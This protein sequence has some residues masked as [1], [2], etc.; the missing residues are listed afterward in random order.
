MADTLKL[1]IE[2]DAAK[3]KIT[4]IDLNKELASI[5]RNGSASAGGMDQLT[6]SMLG[7]SSAARALGSALGG[8]SLIALAKQAIELSASF[9]AT[10]MGIRA[11][12]G[13]FKIADDLLRNLEDF[14]RTSPFNFTNLTDATK[15]LLAYGFTAESI[16]PMLKSVGAASSA[17]GLGNDGISRMTLSL[18]QMKAAGKATGEELREMAQAGVPVWEILSKGFEKTPGQMRKA[19]EAGIVP[20]D[21]AIRILLEGMDKRFGSAFAAA[22][23]STKTVMSNLVDD[24]QKMGREIGDIFAPGLKAWIEDIRPKISEF[25]NDVKAHSGDILAFAGSLGEIAKVIVAYEVI[26][27]IGKLTVAIQGLTAASA[28]NPFTIIAAG[29]AILTV[30]LY[31]QYRQL[32]DTAAKF[33]E[34]E[35]NTRILDNLKTGKSVEEMQ[36]LGFS[37]EQIK[38]ALQGANPL[39]EQFKM[40]PKVLAGVTLG[41][42]LAKPDSKKGEFTS[43]PDKAANSA[44]KTHEEI[45]RKINELQRE[46][47]TGVAKLIVEQQQELVR[48]KAKKATSEDIAKLNSAYAVAIK[49]Q[50][51]ELDKQLDKI[52]NT[53]LAKII[54]QSIEWTK[55][56]FVLAENLKKVSFETDKL[57][58]EAGI[59]INNQMALGEQAQKESKLS[60]LDREDARGGLTIA[61]QR[62]MNKER[63]AIE[64]EYQNMYSL[65]QQSSIEEKF[66]IARLETELNVQ[67]MNITDEAKAHQLKARLDILDRLKNTELGGVQINTEMAKNRAVENEANSSARLV[68]DYYR[69]T[70]SSLKDQAGR[71]LDALFTKSE[72]VWK[73]MA[74]SF[75]AAFLTAFK[76]IV[77]SQIAKTLMG[78]FTGQSVRFQPNTIGNGS[79]SGVSRTLQ[80]LGATGASIMLPDGVGWGMGFSPLGAGATP[81]VGYGTDGSEQPRGAAKLPGIGIFGR[82][83]DTGESYRSMLTSLGGLGRGSGVGVS[84]INSVPLSEQAGLSSAR[85]VG[86][87]AG[88]AML[89]GGGMLAFDGLR[90]GGWLGAAETTGGGALI[91]AKFGGPVGAAIG[92]G[93]GFA[94]GMIRMAFKSATDKMRKRVKEMTGIDVKEKSVLQSMVEGAK[95]FGNFDL[96]INSKAG[97]ELIELYAQ[98]TNQKFKSKFY[99]QNLTMVQSGGSLYEMPAFYG[100]GQTLNPLT[101]LPGLGFSSSIDSLSLSGSSTGSTTVTLQID[102]A[103]TTKLM[104]GEAVNVIANNPRLIASSANAASRSS[105]GRQDQ[106]INLL[107]P[108]LARA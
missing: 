16:L 99:G 75:K 52:S 88:G 30:H 35:D 60:W 81:S 21:D 53:R 19:V 8:L 33:K 80:G 28:I 51:D 18:G 23:N 3:A 106:Q 98:N 94:A 70:F 44:L 36:K 85:G 82:L 15:R 47:L 58:S 74:N 40:D 76:D 64:I 1:I 39:L 45:Q 104:Q 4:V 96:Y 55:Q 14:A 77:S 5:G 86:G 93:I 26:T 107:D 17:L 83:K 54:N 41:I 42:D 92:A 29:A 103:A 20:A 72:S 95:A 68:A 62:E 48:L 2:V 100:N 101:S 57:A 78:L 65:I 90:R 46:E 97:Q 56:A 6:S 12:I 89:M 63:L 22:S 102:G 67:A 66:R 50:Y 13:D 91:G 31:N 27:L 59:G 105:F 49:S 24:L 37:I 79:M 87:M 69:Q 11:M 25:A 71:V 61:R 43:D 34:M 32:Q 84:N 38:R 73:S 108:S 7:G 9:E 10:Q